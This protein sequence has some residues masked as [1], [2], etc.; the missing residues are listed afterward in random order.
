MLKCARLWVLRWAAAEMAED[1]AICEFLA[2]GYEGY[3]L[4]ASS[5]VRGESAVGSSLDRFSRLYGHGNQAVE[6]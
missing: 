3:V 5:P 1:D 4:C 6:A 2:D